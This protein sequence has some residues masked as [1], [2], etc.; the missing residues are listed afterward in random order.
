VHLGVDE[1]GRTFAKK[2][3]RNCV[4]TFEGMKRRQQMDSNHLN[5]FF[6]VSIRGRVAFSLCCITA[7]I[8]RLK[9]D[10]LDWE[11]L[12]EKLWEYTSNKYL[13]DWH[14]EASEYIPSVIMQYERYNADDF[15]FITEDLFN[16]LRVLYIEAHEDINEMIDLTF[17][18]GSI[19]LYG[20]A[21]G[22]G[23]SL[24]YLEGII[25]LMNR[26][27]LSLPSISQFERHRF[28]ESRG[29]GDPFKREDFFSKAAK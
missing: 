17:Y 2:A 3:C 8:E 6:N 20:A 27:S 22:Q 5:G 15:E 25:D 26:H 9:K 14:D 13:D 12:L 16:R 4:P 21:Q 24:E 18:L 19:E 28:D 11:F 10:D 7:L 1:T 23:P 29:W